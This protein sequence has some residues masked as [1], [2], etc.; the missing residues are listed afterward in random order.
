MSNIIARAT[1]KIRELKDYGGVPTFL[2]G[3]VKYAACRVLQPVLRFN[4]WLVSPYEWRIYAMAASRFVTDLVR[5]EGLKTVVEVG[6][7]WGSILAHIKAE[8]RVGFD[9]DAYTVRLARLLHRKVWFHVGTFGDVHLPA[10]VIIAVNF[11]HRIEPDSLRQQLETIHSQTGA[12]YIVVDRVPLQYHHDF[13]RV[14]GGIGT[15]IWRIAPEP[16]GRRE[17]LCYRLTDSSTGR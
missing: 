16:D 10:D 12:R 17:L 14:L 6:C 2:K 3:G 9:K 15:C 7:G 4:P 5:R 13:D 11:I 1:R 8:Q